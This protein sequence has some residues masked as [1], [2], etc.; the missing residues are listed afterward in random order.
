MQSLQYIPLQ[1]IPLQ[2]LP[3]LTTLQAL[4]SHDNV[5]KEVMNGNLSKYQNIKDFCNGQSS[6]TNPLFSNNHTDQSTQLCM[7]DVC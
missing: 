4:L 1:Y 7:D 6:K 3:L 5:F 2:Y